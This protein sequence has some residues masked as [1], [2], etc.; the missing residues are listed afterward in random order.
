M[1]PVEEASVDQLSPQQ[2]AAIHL[3]TSVFAQIPDQTNLGIV[4]GYYET[5]TLFPITGPANAPRQTQVYSSVVS[6]TVGQNTNIQNLE[7]TVTIAFRLQDKVD[8]VSY[9]NIMVWG[10]CKIII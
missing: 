2:N 7:E 6:A 4:V 1:I 8:V 10:K 3:P 9:Y 5:A